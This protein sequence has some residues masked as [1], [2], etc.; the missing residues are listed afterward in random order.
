MIASGWAVIGDS[1]GSSNDEPDSRS[2]LE[3]HEMRERLENRAIAQVIKA[4]GFQTTLRIRVGV[5]VF[6]IPFLHSLWF[7]S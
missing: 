2:P 5:V 1:E 7:M 4:S 3:V 6:A